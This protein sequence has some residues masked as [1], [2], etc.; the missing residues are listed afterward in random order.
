MVAGSE[1]V[2]GQ[3]LQKF[4]WRVVIRKALGEVDGAGFLGQQ[5][6][7][8]ENADANVGE[9]GLEHGWGGSGEENL[10]FQKNVMPS[11]AKHL[12]RV[13]NPIERI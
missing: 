9:F 5:G 7:L 10:G 4:L 6:H 1:G 3:G 11:A 13:S 2:A 12:Y 8:G